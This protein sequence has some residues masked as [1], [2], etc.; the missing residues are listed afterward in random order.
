MTVEFL[1]VMTGATTVEFLFVMTGAG[2]APDVNGG[3]PPI[4]TVAGR[5]SR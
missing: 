3:P 1:F 5:V 4:M 2:P